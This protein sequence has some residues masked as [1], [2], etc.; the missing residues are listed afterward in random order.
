MNGEPSALVSDRTLDRTLDLILVSRPFNIA[1]SVRLWL[2]DRTLVR[3]SDRT[4]R[5]HVRSKLTYAGIIVA[6]AHT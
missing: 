1:E 4:R 3:C 2:C 6:H 5:G